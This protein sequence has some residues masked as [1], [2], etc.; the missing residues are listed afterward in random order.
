M[1]CAQAIYGLVETPDDV[2]VLDEL[3]GGTTKISVVMG[4]FKKADDTSQD[5][6][7]QL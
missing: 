4:V 1:H 6:T 3:R 2:V 5:V 7:C